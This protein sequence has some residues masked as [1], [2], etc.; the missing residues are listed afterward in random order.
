MVLTPTFKTELP[1]TDFIEDEG[2]INTKKAITTPEK[3]I[4]SSDLNPHYI[5]KDAAQI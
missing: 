3:Q 2:E 5:S 1:K 4:F